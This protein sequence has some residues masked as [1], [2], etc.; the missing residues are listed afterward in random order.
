MLQELP[1]S[2]AHMTQTGELFGETNYP[3]AS[4][5]WTHWWNTYANIKHFLEESKE[6]QQANVPFWGNS[7]KFLPQSSSEHR[8]TLPQAFLSFFVK[9]NITGKFA[10]LKI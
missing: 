6:M 8:Q 3:V 4:S 9:G 5:T 2:D 10:F 1:P 7:L